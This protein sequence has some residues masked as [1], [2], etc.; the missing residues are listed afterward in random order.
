MVI[1]NLLVSFEDLQKQVSIVTYVA[2]EC[3]TH[4]Y[5][6]FNIQLIALLTPQSL[7]LNALL[8]RLIGVQNNLSTLIEVNMQAGQVLPHSY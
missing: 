8:C 4:L 5:L 1:Y 7:A 2:C 3:Y 6:L